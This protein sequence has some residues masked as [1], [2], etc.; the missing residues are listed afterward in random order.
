MS[1]SVASEIVSTRLRRVAIVFAL[2][3]TLAPLVHAQQSKRTETATSTTSHKA[4]NDERPEQWG[5]LEV[6]LPGPSSGNPFVDVQLTATFQQDSD[7]HSVNGFYDGEGTYRARFMPDKTG[8]WQYTTHSNVRE[9]DSKTGHFDVVA[10][11]KNNHGPVRVRN[12][13]HFAYADGTPHKPIGTTCYAW[14][15]QSKELEEQTL[16]TLAASPFNKLRM[17][18]FPKWYTWNKNEPLLY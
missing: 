8:R 3:L 17:C 11:S 9:L 5:V 2:T 16:K 18:V 4:V 13:F 12:T 15:S 6:S 10:P 7:Q 14:T 1:Q